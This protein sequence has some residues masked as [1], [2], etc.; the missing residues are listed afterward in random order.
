M[1]EPK[2]AVFYH[3]GS[4][5]VSIEET[6]RCYRAELKFKNLGP[7]SIY[8]PYRGIFSLEIQK[9]NSSEWQGA[10]QYS[11]NTYPPPL[12]PNASKI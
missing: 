9:T 2:P 5:Q 12:K 6:Q 11:F 7:G 4:N 1:L 10:D 8:F 3:Y